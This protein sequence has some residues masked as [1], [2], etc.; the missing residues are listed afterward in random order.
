[1]VDLL[2]WDIWKHKNFFKETFFLKKFCTV[3][4]CL[5]GVNNQELETFAQSYLDGYIIL[6]VD[7][8]YELKHLA[9]ITFASFL[10]FF[11]CLVS[12]RILMPDILLSFNFFKLKL[13]FE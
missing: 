11:K 9:L 13:F 6:N 5:R 2:L 10:Q 3:N 4:S 1:M 8:F 7:W 12:L